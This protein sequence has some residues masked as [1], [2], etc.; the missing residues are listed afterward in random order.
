MWTDPLPQVVVPEGTL[1]Q[2]CLTTLFQPLPPTLLKKSML[3]V[4][5]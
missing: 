4:W 3:Y 2:Y 1:W 5:A